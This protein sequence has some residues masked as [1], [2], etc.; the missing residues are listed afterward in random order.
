MEGSSAR[1]ILL[2][3]AGLAAL[4]LV[5]AVAAALEAALVAVGVPRATLLAGAADA[6]PG[7]RALGALVAEPE[8]T[9]FTLRA[10]GTFGVLFAGVLA[11]AAGP[12]L[13]P[14]V[15][16]GLARAVTGLV[17]GLLSL[18]LAPLARGL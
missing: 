2:F 15:P 17:A 18:P 8:A 5:R 9:A 10:A 7:A 13:L 11:G 12:V 6:T 1:E 3:L 4:L 16:V 14:G